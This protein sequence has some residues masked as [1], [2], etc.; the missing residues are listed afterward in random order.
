MNIY[1]VNDYDWVAAEDFDSAALFYRLHTGTEIDHDEAYQL[2][3]DDLDRLIF[4]AEEG[5]YGLPAGRYT[6][7]VAL[8]SATVGNYTEPF[9]FASTEI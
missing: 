5:C 8:A 6:F 1:K 3:D 7:R 2:N 4:A 9:L